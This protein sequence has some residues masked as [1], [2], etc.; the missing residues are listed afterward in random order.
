MWFLFDCDGDGVQYG[1][2]L[3]D[4]TYYL[5]GCNYLST[6]V[7]MPQ[8]SVWTQYDCDGDGVINEDE[9]ADNTD[10]Q[11]G[12]EFVAASQTVPT[13]STWNAWDCDED[14]VTNATETSDNTNLN[15]PCSFIA[16]SITLPVGDEYNNADCDTDG[17]N[18]ATEGT[19]TTDPFNPD[20]D[21]DGLNDGQEV[22]QGSDPLD[23]CDPVATNSTC[24][25]I[26][27]EGL[28]PNGD[29][30]NDL[31]EIIGAENF[32]NNKLTIY[33][34]YGN[35]VYTFSPGYV[36]Q[37]V[38]QSNSTMNLGGDKLPDGVYF[39]VFDKF[40]DAS[41]ESKGSVYLKNK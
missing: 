25:F 5:D 19:L 29:G 40:G 15:D 38:G 9:M 41:D 11:D 39:Y 23:A 30:I 18:N 13:S 6:S 22:A 27:P 10:V 4:S 20:T 12:C 1:D 37:W 26:I 17:L 3:Q 2:E 21:G 14:G 35:E 8:S 31:F 24:L 7:T 34:R 16:A 33:N 36:N 32:P 28:S